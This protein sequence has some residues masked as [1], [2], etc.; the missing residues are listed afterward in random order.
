[1]PFCV[2]DV[3]LCDEE[4]ERVVFEPPADSFP[5]PDRLDV[6]VEPEFPVA[7][8]FDVPVDPD[9]PVPVDDDPDVDVWMFD[10]M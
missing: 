7:D 4:P 1:V 2:E 10:N 9:V 6:P 3:P 5:D 8:R